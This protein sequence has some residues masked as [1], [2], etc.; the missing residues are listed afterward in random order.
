MCVDVFISDWRV[1]L[2]SQTKM[3][4]YYQIK[5]EFG[6]EEYLNLKS[7]HSR[8]NIAKIRS[9]SH[10]LMIERGRYSK[11]TGVWPR[12]CRFCCDKDHVLGF[13]SLPFFEGTILENEEHCL[14]ECPM[15]DSVRSSLSGD[16]KNLLLL[17]KYK[18]TMNSAHVEE[19]GKFLSSC[20]RIRN[21]KNTSTPSSTQPSDV[22]GPSS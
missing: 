9:S 8:T 18:D 1:D 12:V 19:L 3:Q 13:E 4:F 7:R 14:T 11:E 5:E 16:L 2:G 21:P 20:H 15:Y 10:D 17:R 6:E 22:L